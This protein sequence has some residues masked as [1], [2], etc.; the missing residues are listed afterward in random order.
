MSKG[1]F[2]G[3]W[4]RLTTRCNEDFASYPSLMMQSCHGS[5]QRKALLKQDTHGHTLYY[6]SITYPRALKK[7]A[8]HILR[9]VDPINRDENYVALACNAVSLRRTTARGNA[10]SPKRTHAHTNTQATA[11]HTSTNTH[12][13]DHHNHKHQ[14]QH[15]HETNTYVQAQT[16]TSATAPTGGEI[17]N[18]DMAL[19]AETASD[20]PPPS[21]LNPWPTGG[22]TEGSR[23]SLPCSARGSIS[24]SRG[25]PTVRV[26]V[27]HIYLFIYFG[28]YS[29]IP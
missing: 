14:H 16:H 2:V 29:F 7:R 15:E 21:F 24:A 13:Q 9:R 28:F 23:S 25:L 11:T 12:A 10:S 20:A 17:P 27:L 4:R 1:T 18:A 22:A 5:K 8:Q 26:P 3:Q 19:L 6:Q